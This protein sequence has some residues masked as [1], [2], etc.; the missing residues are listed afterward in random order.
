MQIFENLIAKQNKAAAALPPP[1]AWPEPRRTITQE[2]MEH[3]AA[4]PTNEGGPFAARRRRNRL[5]PLG[6]Q[7]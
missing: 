7:G 5:H 1:V 6:G 4:K 2:C 3:H